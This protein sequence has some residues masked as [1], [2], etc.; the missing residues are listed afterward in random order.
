MDWPGNKT[1][2][3]CEGGK[4][5]GEEKRKIDAQ[6]KKSTRVSRLDEEEIFIVVIL[7]RGYRQEIR[8]F[9]LVSL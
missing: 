3:E 2:E 7:R 9:R 8:P 4:K 5:W 6:G 1:S